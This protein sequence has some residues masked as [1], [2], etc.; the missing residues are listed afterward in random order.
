VGIPGESRPVA[1][2]WQMGLKDA[3]VRC[4]VYRDANGLQIR[5]ESSTAVIVSEPFELQPRTFA[6]SQ[7]LRDSLRRRGWTDLN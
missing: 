2:L 1:T 6:R 5:V 3:R 4:T 7:A